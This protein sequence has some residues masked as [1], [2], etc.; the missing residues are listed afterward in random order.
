[1]QKFPELLGKH[2]SSSLRSSVNPKKD[3]NKFFN[4]K[5]FRASKANRF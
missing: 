3:K 4:Y 5:N 2:L 1:M